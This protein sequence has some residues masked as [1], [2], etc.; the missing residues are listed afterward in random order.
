MAHHEEPR[1]GNEPQG[2]KP[3]AAKRTV[4]PPQAGQVKPPKD[5]GAP[6]EQH[7]EK[8]RQGSFGGKGEHPRTGNRGHQ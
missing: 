4:N 1:G 7:D 6:D 3:S 2:Q 5:M 8:G